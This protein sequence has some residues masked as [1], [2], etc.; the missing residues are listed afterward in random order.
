MIRNGVVK[1]PPTTGDEPSQIAP[2][3]IARPTARAMHVTD[4]GIERVHVEGGELMRSQ[5]MAHTYEAA[6]RNVSS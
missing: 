5:V 4:T 2:A 1:S 3:E 6:T